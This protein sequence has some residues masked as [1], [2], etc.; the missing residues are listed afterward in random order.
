MT[1]YDTD[2]ALKTMIRD[3]IEGLSPD[4]R[5]IFVDTDNEIREAVY[6]REFTSGVLAQVRERLDS[7]G[8]LKVVLH[9]SAWASGSPD[10]HGYRVS[11]V[12]YLPDHSY[13]GIWRHVEPSFWMDDDNENFR[14]AL[15]R[16]KQ[17]FGE[18]ET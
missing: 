8:V 5:V 17:L 3:Q 15:R 18:Q 9:V 1:G 13:H 12:E 2:Y 11:V 10:G 4:E 16:T 14:T 6:P 7:Q